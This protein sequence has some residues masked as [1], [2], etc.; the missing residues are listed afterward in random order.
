MAMD[1]ADAI[2]AW[3]VACE[4]QAC[5][6]TQHDAGLLWN[7]SIMPVM[8]RRLIIYACL[9]LTCACTVDYLP[10]SAMASIVWIWLNLPGHHHTALN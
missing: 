5:N 7:V 8:S 1:G 6:N 4:L 2:M 3:K 10:A 9:F